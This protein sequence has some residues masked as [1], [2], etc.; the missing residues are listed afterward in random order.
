M[1]EEWIFY[2]TLIYGLINGLDSASALNSFTEEFL[3]K[4][5][6][7]SYWGRLEVLQRTPAEL[8]I[9]GLSNSNDGRWVAALSLGYT[10][11]IKSWDGFELGLGGSVTKDF[12]AGEFQAAYS[13]NPLTAKV[14]LQLGAMKMQEF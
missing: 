14:F 9:Q 4:R 7:H 2:N 8:Q 13:G 11:Q 12:L 5:E 3:F 10:R 1:G 6:T